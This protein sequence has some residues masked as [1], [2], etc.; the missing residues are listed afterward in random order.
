MSHQDELIAKGWGERHPLYSPTINVLMLY[1]PRTA[2]ELDVAKTVEAVYA[3]GPTQGQAQQAQPSTSTTKG[4][5]APQVKITADL[6][7][8]SVSRR[9]PSGD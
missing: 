5:L 2:D 8:N 6:R 4:A 7:T 3:T 9:A 1:G